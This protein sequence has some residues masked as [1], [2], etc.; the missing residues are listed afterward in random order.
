MGNHVSP[1]D[2]VVPRRRTLGL[3]LG[4]HAVVMA[5]AAGGFAAVAAFSFATVTFGL[6]YLGSSDPAND[7]AIS[8]AGAIC[9]DA[10]PTAAAMPD[11]APPS[12]SATASRS[13]AT[14]TPARTRRAARATSAPVSAAT[15]VSVRFTVDKSWDGGFQGQVTITN[16]TS[17]GIS[18]WEIAI[19]LPGD[20]V[21]SV[22][23][24]DGRVKGDVLVLQPTSSDAPIPPGGALSAFFVARGPT[25][26][27]VS[28][29][30]DGTT[31]R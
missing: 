18:G 25:T 22:W 8:C 10:G 2:H 23:A 4:R 26:S 29:T 11:F 17:A 6:R 1:P 3:W 21:S 19:T 5:I 16:R 24:A 12:P 20:H 7:I 28:C 13:R 14:P 15:G 27:P 9:G 30:F 31:C